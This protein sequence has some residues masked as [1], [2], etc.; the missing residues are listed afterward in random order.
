M[1]NF[2]I[3]TWSF[4]AVAFVSCQTDKPEPEK[5]TPIVISLTKAEEV[6]MQQNNAFA[7][8]LLRTVSQ[9]ETE[10]KNI[11][12]SP[13]SATIALAMLN[14]GAG[15]QTHKEI[16]E[17]LG[18]GDITQDE[19]NGYFRKM[20]TAMQEADTDVAFE[21]A[22]SIWIRRNFSVLDAFKD[23]NR[24]YYDAEVRNEDFNNPQT[25]D[26]INNW[27]ADKTH[28]KIP[29]IIDHI[30][31]ATVMFLIH[32]LYF[33][34]AWT[35]QF[36]K[37]ATGT[38][39][40]THYDGT[41]TPAPIMRLKESF[42]HG[43][44]E[45]FDLL[46]LPYGNGSFGMIVLLP[47]EGVSLQSVVESLNAETWANGLQQMYKKEVS[48]KLPRFK[49]EY[50]KDLSDDLKTMGMESMFC[51]GC[52]DFSRITNPSTL[53]VTQVKQKT[54]AEV[55]E[56]GA[57]AAAVTV[58]VMGPTSTGPSSAV[59][60]HATRPFLYFIREQSTGA[61]LFSGACQSL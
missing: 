51:D 57:E 36:D 38:E 3:I 26:V 13:L 48:L 27:C 28:Q 40:F 1:R 4:L 41:Q 46:E 53:L 37:H 23:V 10:G 8:D 7:F 33:K 25:I 58:V 11:L 6:I 49:I 14:N 24:D 44:G 50:E 32:A 21:T 39:F 31:E 34:A 18:Y 43:E 52:A 42:A 59:D 60:F 9:H 29:G 12:L 22:H 54:F 55:N 2:T 5:R 47:K 20:L 45:T 17:T 19:M 30:D 15:G 16:Q 61:I 56:E 35:F